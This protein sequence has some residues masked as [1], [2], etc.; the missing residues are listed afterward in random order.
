VSPSSS[1]VAQAPALTSNVW[2]ATALRHETHVLDPQRVHVPPGN[3]PVG[4][5]RIARSVVSFTSLLQSV[6]CARGQFCTASGAL[7]PPIRPCER[8]RDMLA[9]TMSGAFGNGVPWSHYVGDPSLTREGVASLAKWFLLLRPRIELDPTGFEENTGSFDSVL[10]RSPTGSFIGAAAPSSTPAFVFRVVR[11]PGARFDFVAIGRNE[12][13]D[14]FLP[15]VSVSRFHAFLRE[16]PEGLVVQDARSNNGTV[17]AGVRVPRQGE[18]APV[19]VSSGT[20]IRFGDVHGT[21]LNADDLWSA[22]RASVT[23]S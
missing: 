11:Q 1:F 20:N 22:A 14:V 13:N 6:Q 18:G 3:P 8:C 5:R 10:P 19:V 17:A 23:G 16:T 2:T 12:K 4:A 7:A 9:R 15:D 21:V